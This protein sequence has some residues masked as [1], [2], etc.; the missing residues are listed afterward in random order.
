MQ[1][2]GSPGFIGGWF[3]SVPLISGI[4]VIIGAIL[5]NIR[6]Q[7]NTTWGIIVL[8]FSIIGFTGMGLSIIGGILGIIGGA[9]ALSRG[10]TGR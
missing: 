1:L 6:P 4:L 8:L 7:E 9:I 3:F 2:W 10:S 5:M